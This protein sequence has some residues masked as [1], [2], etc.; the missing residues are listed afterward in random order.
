MGAPTKRVELTSE[1]LA[2]LHLWEA[3]GR[4]E[5]RLAT[6]ARVVLAAVEGLSLKNRP[7]LQ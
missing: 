3:S 2:T 4:T 7:W 6:R 5:Q 1:D